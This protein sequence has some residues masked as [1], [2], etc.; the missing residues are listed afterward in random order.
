M[1]V[2]HLDI[3]VGSGYYPAKALAAGV[4]CKE[5]TIVDLNLNSL[6]ATE[7]RI[8][9]SS[10]AVRVTAVVADATEHLPLPESARFDS[11]SMFHLLHCVPGPPERKAKAF[12]VVR[13]LLAPDGVLVGSTVLGREQ[14]M[15]WIAAKL[16]SIYNNSGTFDNWNDSR[17]VFEEALRK[18]F[19]QV[20]IQLVGRV[21]L[22]TAR[23]PRWLESDAG[24]RVQPEMQS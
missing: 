17:Y 5:I 24:T 14:P 13:D 3:G 7:N 4:D 18:N 23:K 2:R 20:S 11:I 19:E 12:N 1:G 22:F 10:N 8:I 6:A 21:M 15:N 9:K 16:M